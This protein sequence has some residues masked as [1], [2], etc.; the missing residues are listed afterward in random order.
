MNINGK[1]V[2]AIRIYAVAQYDRK[3]LAWL[4]ERLLLKHDRLLNHFSAKPDFSGVSVFGHLIFLQ[5][6]PL[7]ETYS[8]IN[9]FTFS[10][11]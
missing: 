3:F 9:N 1:E 4:R 6:L 8:S 5:F 2:D 10:K 11:T 7:D